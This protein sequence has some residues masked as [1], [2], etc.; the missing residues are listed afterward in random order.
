MENQS[1][2]AT[3]SKLVLERLRSDPFRG[4]SPD[5]VKRRLTEFGHN[6][7]RKEE[8]ISPSAL[9][10]N[11]FK[12]LL[13]II[14]LV[15]VVLS[16]LV[17]EVLD[18]AMIGAIV[19]LS[20]LL[21][22]FQEYKAEQA[23]EALKKML[24]PTITVLRDGKEE[25]VPSK[26]LVPGDILLLEAGDKIPADARLLEVRSLDCDEAPLT[27]ESVP[28]RKDTAPL[29]LDI[30]VSDR[31]NMIYAGTIVTYGRGKAIVAATG[32]NTEFGKIAEEVASAE[33]KKTPLEK[34]TDEI[35]RWLGIISFSICFVVA[36][37]SSAREAIFGRISMKFLIDSV[38]FAV[39]LAIAAVPEALTAIVTGALA[40]GM[41]QMAKRNALVRR[42]PAVETLG[43]ATVICSDKTGTLTKGQMTVRRIFT[44]DSLIEVTGAGYEPA[45]EFKGLKDSS[46]QDTGPLPMLLRGALLC[47]DSLLEETGGKWTIKGD[48]TE[49]A[50]VVAAVKAGLHARETRLSYPRIEEIPFSSER[51]R[52]TTVHKV[53]DGTIIAFMKG[54]PEEILG[55]CSALAT[56]EGIRPLRAEDREAAL[57][58]NRE[59]A[60][61]ALRVLGL[62]FRQMP[63]EMSRF[64]EEDE[65]G[66][67]FLGLAG[68]MDPPREEAVEAVR[69]CKKIKIKT[70]MITGDHEITARAIAKEIGI[71]EEGDLVLDGEKLAKM[72]VEELERIVDKVTV[73]ARVSPIDKLK[74]V[75]AWKSRGEVVAMTGDGVNDAPALKQADIGIAMG[76]T[77]TE[78]TKDASD[79][80]LSDDNFATIL[81]AIERGRWIYD[82][83]KKYLTYLLRCNITE[84][85]VIG[86]IVLIKG[87]D[88]LPLLA[89]AILYINLVTDGLPALALGIAPADPDIMERPPRDPKESVFSREVIVFI[90]MALLIETP[91]LYFLFFHDFSDIAQARTEIFFLFIVV[92]LVIALNFRSLRFSIFKVPPHRWLVLAILSQLI[93]SAVLIQFP[94]V[95]KS[96]GILRPDL[97]MIGIIVGFSLFVF[98]AMEIAKALLKRRLTRASDSATPSP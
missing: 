65:K 27:G 6:E 7:L 25:D 68:M 94:S 97:R 55:R 69:T 48:P 29:S 44:A 79:L 87:P 66:M 58:A 67:V 83:I 8:K 60:Q 86:G 93:L 72:P 39:A 47:N 14:L 19:I 22:F 9:F 26:S 64:G 24:S 74:I 10:L 18:A 51:K 52:M 31:N 13:I 85:A 61:A 50:L 38:M 62:A 41:H 59:M 81:K 37:V 70:V 73:Y 88:Y 42:M 2:H 75:R 34:R 1:W 98:L 82:N 32:M 15:A 46:M 16:I 5:E 45:G 49:G 92:E 76:I 23:L 80:V 36:G 91:F 35:G 95:R 28:V 3:D 77:G 90:L 54:A 56:A 96:F 71:Y 43:C 57:R 30:P 84:V 89:A 17:G 63:A 33:L 12:N 21:G 78:V 4:L 20:A 40:I 53:S 11:Q